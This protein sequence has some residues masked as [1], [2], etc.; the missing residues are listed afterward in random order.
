[1]R[2]CKQ[3]D[4]EHIVKDTKRLENGALGMSIIA[5]FLYS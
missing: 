3:T 5:V 2:C 4:G 1:M